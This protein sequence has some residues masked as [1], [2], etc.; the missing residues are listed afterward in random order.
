MTIYILFHGLL[1]I[2]NISV[3]WA[4]FLPPNSFAL[5]E[6]HFLKNSILQLNE[7]N[8]QQNTQRYVGLCVTIPTQLYV[9]N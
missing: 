5:K 6:K 9:K 1:T 4:H 8:H 3:N 2:I 7:I